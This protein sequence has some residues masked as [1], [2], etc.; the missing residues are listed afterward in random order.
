MLV[1]KCLPTSRGPGG[2][3]FGSREAILRLS[4]S[5]DKLVLQLCRAP[6]SQLRCCRGS[7]ERETPIQ[8]GFEAAGPPPTRGK[9]GCQQR[10]SCR[11]NIRCGTWGGGI[12]QVYRYFTSQFSPRRLRLKS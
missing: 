2:G 12:C 9:R 5:P 10:C 6:P 3:W 1:E 11:L 4:H 8:T 7:V